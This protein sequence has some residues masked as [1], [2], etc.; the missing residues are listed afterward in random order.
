MTDRS[1]GISPED[2]RLRRDLR[3]LVRFIGV[4][5]RYKHADAER[6]P[7]WVKGFDLDTLAKRLPTLCPHCSKLLAHAFVKRSHCPMEP[8]PACKHCSDHCYHPT[9]RARIREVMRYS[10]RRLV[11]SGRLD[12]LYHLLF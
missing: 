9:Y 11:L 6:R 4:Y 8:K 1:A 5:C 3:T 7:A 12:L 2:P 10:G